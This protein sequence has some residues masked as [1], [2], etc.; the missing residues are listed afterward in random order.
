MKNLMK[1]EFE[2]MTPEQVVA[3]VRA[4][5]DP[6]PWMVVTNFMVQGYALWEVLGKLDDHTRIE[7]P[8]KR[9]GPLQCTACGA[10]FVGTS[11]F[12][13]HRVGMRCNDPLAIGYERTGKGV[14]RKPFEKPP[15]WAE[16]DDVEAR[17]GLGSGSG[18]DPPE[19]PYVR[20]ITTDDVIRF[21]EACRGR[22]LPPAEA[23]EMDALLRQQAMDR[24]RARGWSY[25]GRRA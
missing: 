25:G 21:R 23:R 8:R 10:I 2:A 3:Q 11:G 7:A 15:V 1:S 9:P 14:W 22:G 19:T 17:M 16:T 18:S 5:L 13:D 20:R 4:I 24:I 12:K 6:G